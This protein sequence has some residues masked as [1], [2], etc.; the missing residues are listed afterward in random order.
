MWKRDTALTWSIP[1]KLYQK[2]FLASVSRSKNHYRY[3]LAL[4]PALSTLGMDAPHGCIFVHI[5]MSIYI[6]G[7]HSCKLYTKFERL[8]VCKKHHAGPAAVREVATA[9]FHPT[10]FCRG[11][12]RLHSLHQTTWM[13]KMPA[14]HKTVMSLHWAP[15]ARHACIYASTV[16]ECPS[17][18]QQRMMHNRGWFA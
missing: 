8:S 3:V 14:S 16:W 11:V 13:H 17:D 1:C 10:C 4:K 9:G 15:P 18:V 6:H 5:Y 12:L 7:Q 2:A